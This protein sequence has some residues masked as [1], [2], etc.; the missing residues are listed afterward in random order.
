MPTS[1]HPTLQR[2]VSFHYAPTSTQRQ[3]PWREALLLARYHARLLNWWLVVLMALGFLGAGFL[4]WLP[5]HAGGA[6]AL[7]Q[8]RGLGQFVLEP[9][10]GLL[11][12]SLIVN[13]PLL[14][15]TMATRAGIASMVLW[16]ALLTFLLLLCCS[17]VFLAWSRAIGIS[18]ARQ[19][20]PLSLVLV[21]LAPVLVMGLLSLLGSLLTRNAALGLVI[22]TVPLAGS[23]LLYQKLI[24]IPATHPFF[25]SYT[26]SG[27]QDA[28]DWWTNRL[29]LLGIAGVIAVW[30]WWLLRHEERLLGS[31]Q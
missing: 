19:Q 23:L 21:W 31:G 30:N 9:G 14:E 20:S 12:S 17:A 4:T 22:A 16:R 24:S 29:T 5:L 27:G 13:D 28:P 8:A 11:T 10:A 18:Y 26:F 6:E 15:V 2:A 7:S 25:L 3:R 1:E